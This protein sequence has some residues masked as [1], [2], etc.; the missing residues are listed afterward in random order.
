MHDFRHCFATIA[1][2]LGTSNIQ[3][4]AAT[5]HRT[6]SQLLRYCHPDAASVQQL[7]TKVYEKLVNTTNLSEIIA[8]DQSTGTGDGSD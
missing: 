7:T 4:S 2:V 6:L 8:S 5:G 1:S 3:L